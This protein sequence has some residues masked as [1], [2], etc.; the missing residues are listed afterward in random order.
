MYP[1]AGCT[2]LADP[3]KPSTNC[4]FNGKGKFTGDVEINGNI[5]SGENEEKY[6]FSDVSSN[7]I[8]IGSGSSRV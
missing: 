2:M 7:F 3:P 4:F 1:D 5:I 8:N 6:I